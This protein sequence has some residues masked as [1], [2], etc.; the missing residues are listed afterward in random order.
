M[1]FLD[2]INRYDPQKV[3]KSI[4]EKSTRE[5]EEA[6]GKEH[7]RVKDFAALL[8]PAAGDFLEQ[9]AQ[10]SH[11]ITLQRFGKIIQ[12]YVPLYI[13]NECTNGCLYCGFN[14]KNKIKRKTL[15]L[16]EVEQEALVLHRQGFRH[17]LL[18]T[19]EDPNAANTD[20]LE[21]AVRR[22][23]P[24]FGS[25]AIEVFPMETEE[26]QRMV[27]AGVDSLAVYQETYDRDLYAK[28]HPFG[29]KRDYNFR[30]LTP[31]RGG[32]GGFRKI[33][34]GSLL[35]LGN[36]RRETFFTGLHALYLARHYWRSQISVSFPRIR[37]SDGGFAPLN[38]VSDRQFV[39]LLCA[40]RLLLPDA[41]LVLST[42]ESAQLR[43]NLLP[44][45]ITQMSA[46]SCT[47]PGG[48]SQ[49]EQS[50]EQFAI[51]D[52]RSPQEISRLIRAKGYE[53]VWKDWDSAFLDKAA[54]R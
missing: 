36:F 35:G 48:Y 43:D 14:A 21:A 16:D 54:A 27:E 30:L 9:M 2:E 7:L 52:D 5:V 6:L 10:K 42:R 22:I 15:S 33:G 24:L 37:P 50:T 49:K 46:G 20:Y 31:E 39:Q 19:G 40:M 13:S 25:I 47:A 4:E 41:G 1:S 34:I 17:V 3:L 44:L 11:R 29:K 26:Y 51:D 28:M 8:S 45:G 53:A 12:L 18:L 32:E 23:K 38:P